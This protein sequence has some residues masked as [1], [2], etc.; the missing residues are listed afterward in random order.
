MENGYAI[1]EANP[2]QQKLLIEIVQ[3]VTELIGAK[4]RKF[5]TEHPETCATEQEASDILS[6]PNNALIMIVAAHVSN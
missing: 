4:L 3:E 1:R 2:V 6:L 5:G